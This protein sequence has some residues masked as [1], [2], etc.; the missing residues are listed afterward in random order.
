MKDKVSWVW[1]DTFTKLSLTVGEYKKLKE[2]NFK[3]CLVSPEINSPNLIDLKNIKCII[4]EKNFKFDA[5]CTKFPE[6]WEKFIQ[7]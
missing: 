7:T 6:E 3:L 4:Q 1:V 2:A 5:V